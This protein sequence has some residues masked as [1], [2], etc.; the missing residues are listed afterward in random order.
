MKKGIPV[1]FSLLAGSLPFFAH[2]A[3]SSLVVTATPAHLQLAQQDT[4]GTTGGPGQGAGKQGKKGA[5]GTTQDPGMDETKDDYSPVDDTGTGGEVNERDT[6]A[7]DMEEAG[8]VPPGME[9]RDAHPSTGK[10]SEKG[11]EARNKEKP[12]EPKREKPWYRFWE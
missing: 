1:L 5:A 6:R 2:A 9:K 11:Q 12:N 8:K 3:D 7:N 10:G 4:T